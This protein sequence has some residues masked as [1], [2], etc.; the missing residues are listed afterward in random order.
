MVEAVVVLVAAFMAVAVEVIVMLVT[1]VA[2]V[3]EVV[4]QQSSRDIA[5]TFCV[6]TTHTVE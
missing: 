6:L 1:M 3:V 2:V 4:L 5:S